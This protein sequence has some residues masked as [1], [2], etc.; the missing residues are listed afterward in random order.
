MT[1]FLLFQPNPRRIVMLGLGGGS[2][3]RWCYTSLPDAH[4]SV[5]E[6]SRDVVRL[7]SMFAI[8]ADDERLKVIV[9]DGAEYLRRI[10][11]RPEVLLVDAFDLDGMPSPQ[12]CTRAFYEDCYRALDDQGILVVNMDGD[13]RA[14]VDEIRQIFANRVIVVAPAD[15]E[16]RIVFAIKG[17]IRTAEID[18]LDALTRRF[19]DQFTK[20]PVEIQRDVRQN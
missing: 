18:G 16:N 6:I 9:G 1:G 17:R 2:M 19:I 5:I 20:V 12:T 4:L 10:S 14:W 3:A 8:P 11:D 7:R 13:R 15:G